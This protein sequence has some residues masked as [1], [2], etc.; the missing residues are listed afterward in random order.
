VTDGSDDT[1]RRVPRDQLLHADTEDDGER[2][3]AYLIDARLV[4][5][6]DGTY[7]LSHD[8]LIHTWPRLQQ[9][10]TED[11][12]GLRLHRELTDRARTW[13]R[14]HRDPASLI[15]GTELELARRWA[16]QHPDDLHGIGH[17]FY[18]ASL[19]AETTRRERAKR[20]RLR[21]ISGLTSGLL[22]LA[23]TAS[24]YAWQ[25]HGQAIKQRQAATAA[26][27][28][29][30]AAQ[31]NSMIDADPD[32][33]SLLAVTAYRLD[34]GDDETQA[35]AVT[36][37]LPLTRRLTGHAGPVNAVAFS[38]DG[39]TLATTSDD[40][41]ARL[42]NAHTGHPIATLR[43]HTAI[44]NDVAFSPDVRRRVG[45]SCGVTSGGQGL[46]I[47]RVGWIGSCATTR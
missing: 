21:R 9:W 1:R 28:R 3:L 14:H 13:H 20:R 39:T 7:M 11:R 37:R 15:A 32:L 8:A 23:L 5:A 35:L 24:L 4:T 26:L 33:A 10:L 25:Q 47:T 6:E 40:H 19:A 30:L 45:W 17:D 38:P 12:D 2:I 22:V 44:V 46:W 27:A 34:H 42:W 31:A 41:T 36:S 29:Q 16:T 18:H 43:G